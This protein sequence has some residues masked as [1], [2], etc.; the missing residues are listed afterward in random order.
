MPFFRRRSAPLKTDKH[1]NTWSFL[2][3]DQGTSTV[4]V[5]IVLGVQSA[6]KNSPTECEVGSH[7]RSIYFEF[8]LAA[9]TVTNPKVLHWTIQGGPEGTT[10]EN[11]TTYYQ[12]NRAQIF[13]R[14]ME[15]L[16]TNVSTVY[17]RIFVARVPKKMQRIQENGFISILF[18]CTSMETINNCG[19][20]I[21]K[22]QY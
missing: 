20:A 4:I 8:N 12:G 15:M 21:Y 10:L 16:P 22:E 9:Q 11:P 18:R 6:D 7:V 19:F 13:K 5:P 3:A 1:E 17:K 2:A 14:G